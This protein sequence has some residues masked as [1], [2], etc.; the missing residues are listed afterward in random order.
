M[1]QTLEVRKTLPVVRYRF[2]QEELRSGSSEIDPLVAISEYLI[3]KGFT[4][5]IASVWGGEHESHSGILPYNAEYHN[6][7]CFSRNFISDYQ[8]ASDEA[9]PDFYLDYAYV[10][11]YLKKDSLLFEATVEG[12]H[13]DTVWV[14][15]ADRDACLIDEVM[16]EAR[17]IFASSPI[18]EHRY[19]WS[20]TPDLLQRRWGITV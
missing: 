7:E 1:I 12:K 17:K 18:S 2:L 10:S 6:L 13:L 8:A 5:C 19:T 3:E 9:K 14:K 20:F 11:V 16:D 4:F 15:M